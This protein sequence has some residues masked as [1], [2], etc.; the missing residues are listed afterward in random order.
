M[1]Y[2]MLYLEPRFYPY[3]EKDEI[4]NQMLASSCG[5]VVKAEDT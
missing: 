1:K 2:V 3:L 5:L 4:K